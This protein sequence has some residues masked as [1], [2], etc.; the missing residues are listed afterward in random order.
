MG[1]FK[2][3]N[4]GYRIAPL[5]ATWHLSRTMTYGEFVLFQRGSKNMEDGINAK[6]PE[7]SQRRRENGSAFGN[8]SCQSFQSIME[9]QLNT[10][11]FQHIKAPVPVTL[12]AL[13]ALLISACG[14]GGSSGS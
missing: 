7:S 12:G 4:C 6:H 3:S 14:G 5:R 8:R 9:T 13:S 2:S 11:R 1:N 10:I